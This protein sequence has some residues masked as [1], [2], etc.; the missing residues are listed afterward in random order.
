MKSLENRNTKRPTQ[1]SQN[2]LSFAM[3]EGENLSNLIIY[4][5]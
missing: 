4:D 1:N 3:P 5:L 2:R